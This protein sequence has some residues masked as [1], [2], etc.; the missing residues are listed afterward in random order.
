MQANTNI[1]SGQKETTG[2]NLLHWGILQIDLLCQVGLPENL[3]LKM[4]QA[5]TDGD[6][7][8]V[9]KKGLLS[10]GIAFDKFAALCDNEYCGSF[11]KD[12]IRD[13]MS[14]TM[15]RYANMRGTFFAKHLKTNGTGDLVKKMANSQST[16]AQVANT[17]VSSNRG[18]VTH[19]Q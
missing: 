13:I 7:V 4:M 6:I 3:T 11:D 19:L 15:D 18:Y 1:T 14:Y 5:Y 2:Q 8:D 9:I 10:S 16:R 12:D 17:V